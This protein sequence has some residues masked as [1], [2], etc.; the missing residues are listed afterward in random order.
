MLKLTADF[1]RKLRPMGKLNG[2][3]NGPLMAY[4]DRTDA[5]QEM[6]VD[7]VRFHECHAQHAK[8]IEVP[9]V[10]P[11]FNADEYDPANYY[12]DQTDAVIKAAHDIGAEIM[13]RFG[14]GTETGAHRLFLT[15]PPDYEKWGRIVIQILK[16]YNEGWANGFHYG[17]RWCEI[18]NEADLKQYW[19]GPLSEYAKFYC[20]VAK[21]LR[22]YDPTLLI[23][24]SGFADGLY[25]HPG[26]DA[27]QEKIDAW[28][29]VNEFF[30]SFLDTVRQENIPMDCFP[31][32]CYVLDS[33]ECAH[34]LDLHMNLL[35]AHGM[36]DIELIN[37]EWGPISLKPTNPNLNSTNPMTW[38]VG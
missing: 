2:M 15:V 16:H 29:E 3:N 34:R 18:W 10:F 5:F 4:I 9:F 8:C 38:G 20:T 33:K 32:H 1:S 23:C 24:P 27:P 30:H 35:R 31:W 6:G 14:M 25:E 28:N 13:Y 26:M 21:M 36:E 19:P 22:D 17:I 11:D 12:F 7:Y 37:T